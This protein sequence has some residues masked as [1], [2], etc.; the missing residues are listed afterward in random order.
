MVYRNMMPCSSV[1]RHISEEPATSIFKE[2]NSS[3][4]KMEAADPSNMFVPICQIIQ[5]YIPTISAK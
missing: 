2:E 1:D 5:L 4:Q 3:P